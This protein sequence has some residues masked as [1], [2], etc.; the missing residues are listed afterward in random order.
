[1]KKTLLVSAAAAVLFTS[2]ASHA[3]TPTSAEMEVRVDIERAADL[4][5]TPIDFGTILINGDA[6]QVN[7]DQAGAI[8]SAGG[9]LQTYGTPQA[10][11]L[12]ID[13]NNG[14]VATVTMDPSVALGTEG[15]VFTP[16]ADTTTVNL[17]GTPS[18]VTVYGVVDFP[19]DT[20]TQSLT[21]LLN[22]NVSYN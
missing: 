20:Q 3:A 6:G 4:V 15:V 22:I 21:G 13:A 14:A 9:V 5:V 12:T 10:G 19:A 7:M 17:D 1:M 18:T 8:T 2:G 16:T 11:T